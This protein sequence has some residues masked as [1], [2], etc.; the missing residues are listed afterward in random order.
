MLIEKII[1]EYIYFLIDKYKQI[2]LRSEENLFKCND[3]EYNSSFLIKSKIN[4]FIQ[5]NLFKILKSHGSNLIIHEVDVVNKLII[6]QL[7]GSCMNCIFKKILLMH[8]MNLYKRN[9]R[10]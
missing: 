10:F 3:M 2:D 7:I 4:L 9:R 6:F 1:C 5:D 8:Y